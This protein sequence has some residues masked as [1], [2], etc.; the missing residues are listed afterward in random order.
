MSFTAGP[1]AVRLAICMP[2]NGGVEPACMRSV[3]DLLGACA[4]RGIRATWNYSQAASTSLAKN[5]MAYAA[6]HGTDCTHVFFLDSD[7]KFDALD[8]LRMIDRDVDF[9][10][11]TYRAKFADVGVVQY[12][13]NLDAEQAAQPEDRGTIRVDG[14]GGGL[15]LFKRATLERL[16]AAHPELRYQINGV[17]AVGIFDDL[18]D[19]VDLARYSEDTA[20]CRRLRALGVDVNL[21]I[22][23]KTTHYGRGA[24]GGWEGNYREIWD[25]VQTAGLR[26]GD[27]V[28]VPLGSPAPAVLH[29]GACRPKPPAPGRN[30]PCPCG[31]GQKWKRCHGAQAGA[32]P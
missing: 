17:T 13:V 21:L 16:I 11:A 32:A 10:G 15:M 8:V 28:Q 1:S 25:L 22:D 18:V 31:S 19:P 29:K 26:P 12:V 6:A 4:A 23:A 20:V 2:C 3:I 27:A 24:G 9:I 30:D 7:L 5:E 14:I